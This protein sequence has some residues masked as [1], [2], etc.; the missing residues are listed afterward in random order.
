METAQEK[1][2]LENT[3]VGEILIVG[4]TELILPA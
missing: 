2:S 1:R 4:Y 3:L